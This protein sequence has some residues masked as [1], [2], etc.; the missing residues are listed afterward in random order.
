MVAKRWPCS[1]ST[2]SEPN[3]VSEQALSQQLPLRLSFL[4]FALGSLFVFWRQLSG[5]ISFSL[6]HDHGSHI[7]ILA[8][9]SAF[10]IY[11]K[12]REIFS[13]LQSRLLAGSMLFL[14]GAT[15]YWFTSGGIVFYALRLVILIPVLVALRNSDKRCQPAFSVV[16]A[17]RG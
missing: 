17:S 7:I 5:P 12:R 8:P 3:S 6:T 4:L 11:L 15:F 10:I 9:A 1:R 13:K 16:D 2:F 14:A